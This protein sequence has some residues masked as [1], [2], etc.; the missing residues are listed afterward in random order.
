MFLGKKRKQKVMMGKAEKKVK[1]PME[2]KEG[3]RTLIRVRIK[4][5]TRSHGISVG[6]FTLP[7]LTCFTVAPRCTARGTAI[8]D[9]SSFLK[10]AP[11]TLSNL[12]TNDLSMSAANANASANSNAANS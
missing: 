5:S 7:L 9:F 2:M 3:M 6:Q 12:E 1:M 8:M 11:D 10:G 4:L